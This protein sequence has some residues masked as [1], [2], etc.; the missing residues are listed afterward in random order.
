MLLVYNPGLTLGFEVP[1]GEHRYIGSRLHSQFLATLH[2][3]I[4]RDHFSNDESHFCLHIR[5]SIVGRVL[6]PKI[7]F[8]VVPD[9]SPSNAYE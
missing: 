9:Q 5:S 7:A 4:P 2:A 3:G 6:T 8:T 1:R